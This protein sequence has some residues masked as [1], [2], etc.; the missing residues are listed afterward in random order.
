MFT[1]VF[2]F[3]CFEM[4]AGVMQLFTSLLADDNRSKLKYFRFAPFYML[5]YWM[6]NAITI[7]T[8]FI[9]AVKTILGYGSGVWVSPERTAKKPKNLNEFTFPGQ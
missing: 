1:M 2:L 8:T 4:I 9:P 7:V 6:I 5:F 3:V